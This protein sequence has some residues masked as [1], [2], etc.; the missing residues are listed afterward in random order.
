MDK[1][2]KSHY[3]KDNPGCYHRMIEYL[4]KCDNTS[5]FKEI[6][7]DYISEIKARG[8]RAFN[9]HVI[10]GGIEYYYPR[11]VLEKGGIKKLELSRMIEK[12]KCETI[13]LDDNPIKFDRIYM[14][15]YKSIPDFK[16]TVNHAGKH[17]DSCGD[18][19]YSNVTL[20]EVTGNYFADIECSC[21]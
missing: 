8:Y 10:L 20:Y 13:R 6:D 9:C 5:P 7:L 17:K 21:Y 18:G 12:Y 4:A 1:E 19:W 2:L 11:Y 15:L 16:T 3:T 14:K